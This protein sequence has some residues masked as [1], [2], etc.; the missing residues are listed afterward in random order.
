MQSHV[1]D[2]QMRKTVKMWKFETSIRSKA[3]LDPEK[4]KRR[5]VPLILYGL[6]N[7]ELLFRN[8]ACQ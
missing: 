5:Q 6:E 3:L 1:K 7:M 8:D 4:I 2:N